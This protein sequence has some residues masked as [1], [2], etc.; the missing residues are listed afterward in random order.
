MEKR[1]IL[2]RTPE[3]CS[4]WKCSLDLI[5]KLKSFGID[6]AKNTIHS[7]FN[8]FVTMIRTIKDIMD[9]CNKYELEVAKN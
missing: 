3:H 5:D 2:I 4:I 6:N 7:D 1:V 8:Q 9:T